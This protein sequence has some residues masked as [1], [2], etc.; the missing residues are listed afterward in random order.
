[1]KQSEQPSNKAM[2]QS[3]RALEAA[4]GRLCIIESRFAGYRCC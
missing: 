2:N 1:M 3:K 4:P